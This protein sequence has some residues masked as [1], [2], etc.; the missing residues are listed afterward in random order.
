MRCG[1][2]KTE[3]TCKS[4]KILLM[5]VV[6][7]PFICK[8]IR[9]VGVNEKIKEICD[10]IPMAHEVHVDVPAH[11]KEIDML[12]G[13]GYFWQINMSG[14]V[15]VSDGLF[16]IETQLGW[17]L[18]G[19]VENSSSVNLSVEKALSLSCNVTHHSTQA[20]HNEIKSDF[21]PTTC[22]ANETMM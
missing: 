13:I 14:K 17:T 22:N 21:Y 19:R 9:V 16:L 20:I 1:I 10:S 18:A 5:E 6:L 3:L 15:E 7:V 11:Y 4:G 12:I 2:A 8:A